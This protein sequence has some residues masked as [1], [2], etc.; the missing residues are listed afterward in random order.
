M[1]GI[2]ICGCCCQPHNCTELLLLLLLAPAHLLQTAVAADST[3][4]S[5]GHNKVRHLQHEQLQKVH[6]EEYT[7]A[8]EL[9]LQLRQQRGAGTA[10]TSSSSGSSV[11]RRLHAIKATKQPSTRLQK[12]LQENQASTLRIQP[13]FQMDGG[14]LT[15]QQASQVQDVLVPGA[16]KVLQQYIK[17]RAT[18][19]NFVDGNMK[20]C[21][22]VDFPQ[23]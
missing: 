2:G 19:L 16:I 13:V 9:Y 23:Q 18:R 5:C 20:S 17:V 15:A 14:Y 21:R 12:L 7:Q 4:H 11:A 3:A 1:P 22:A 6:G 8:Q 10:G